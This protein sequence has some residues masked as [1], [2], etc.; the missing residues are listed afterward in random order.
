[1]SDVLLRDVPEPIFR[2]LQNRAL[3]HQRSLEGEALTILTEALTPAIEQDP[4][5]QARQIREELT[6]TGRAFSDSVELLD[7]DRSR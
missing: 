7:E 6:A 3:H 1:M 4:V 2:A 5:Q